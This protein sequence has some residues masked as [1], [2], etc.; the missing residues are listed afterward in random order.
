MVPATFEPTPSAPTVTDLTAAFRTLNRSSR[1]VEEAHLQLLERVQE[2]L[3][4]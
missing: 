1:R 2:A 3:S 4:E